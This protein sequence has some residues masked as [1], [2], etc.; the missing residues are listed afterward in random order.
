[1]RSWACW[2]RCPPLIGSL[3]ELPIGLLAGHGRRQRIAVLA[4][5]GL[6]AAA[7]PAATALSWSFAGLLIASVVFFPASGA[8]VGLTQSGL[9]AAEPARQEQLMAR[10]NLAGVGPGGGRAAAADRGAGGR[11]HL[12]GRYLCWPGRRAGLARAAAAGARRR[13]WWAATGRRAARGRGRRGRGRS[14]PRCGRGTLRWL[15]LIEVA[16]LLVDVF[17]GFLALY[18]VD[19][20]HMTPAVA[21]PAVRYGSA[22]RW[23]GTPRWSWYWSGSAT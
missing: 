22:P 5:G 21:A 7:L 15:L 11:R 23:P 14:V 13:P 17:T 4:G 3:A 20:A 8:F 18:L 16:D 9:I 6:F 19:V 2:S 10:W 12:A 1:M